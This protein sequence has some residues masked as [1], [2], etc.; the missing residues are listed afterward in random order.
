MGK[1]TLELMNLSIKLDKIFSIFRDKTSIII[2]KKKYT[3]N[4]LKTKSDQII[5][6][7]NQQ[8]IRIK[9]V[10]LIFNNKKI[11]EFLMMIA[12]LRTGIIY[13]NIDPSLPGD[14]IRLIIKNLNPKIFYSKKYTKNILKNIDKKKI[15]RIRKSNISS[16]KV[17]NKFSKLNPLYIIYTSGSSGVP[18][19]VC[20]NHNNVINFIKWSKKK[21]SIQSNDNI[22][23]LNPMY[24]DN[25]V[26]DFYNS[27]FNGGTM[28]VFSENDVKK[29]SNIMKIIKN[30][31]CTIWYSVPS[32]LIYCYNLR[33]FEIQNFFK[34]KKIIFAG[35]PYPKYKLYELFKKFRENIIFFNAY[36]PT[37]TTCLCSAHKINLKDF[38][39]NYNLV[40][41]GK[42]NDKNCFFKI[43]AT[44]KNY[45]SKN[46]KQGELHIGGSFVSDGYYNDKKLTSEK[47]YEVKNKKRKIR[48][49]KSGDL[50][51]K[52]KKGFYYYKGRS[53]NQI[54]IMGYRI[55]LED[56]EMNINKLQDV[57]QSCVLFDKN[58]QSSSLVAFISSKKKNLPSL[59]EDLKKILPYYMMPKKFILM[60]SLPFNRNGK[61]D[62]NRLK[63]LI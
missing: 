45:I 33:A 46:H 8:N 24:F 36:G 1:I 4:Y 44:K 61:L 18:K 32:L 58:K 15:F 55:E 13:S 39:S 52:D 62:K 37:E 51:I 41:L 20:I 7:F 30:N 43:K 26:F 21:F 29:T 40:T 59:K 54:K 12:C 14:R 2:G 34:I 10:V 31:N 56:V 28:V 35:E 48:F 22:T 63:K 60:R 53:D 16:L 5:A 50:V 11:E 23:N 57:S 6:Q 3:Y 42:L 27:I 38:K 47:F 9:D 25:S 19:G 49:Y 17:S